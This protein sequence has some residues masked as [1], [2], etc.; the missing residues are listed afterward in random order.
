M[1]SRLDLTLLGIPERRVRG[2]RAGK[3]IQVAYNQVKEVRTAPRA[4]GL[5]GDM[6]GPPP[7]TFPPED[8]LPPPLGL[9]L[10]S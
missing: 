2:A 9:M 1:N 8:H 5:W 6:V 4:F 7:P 3:E 10:L